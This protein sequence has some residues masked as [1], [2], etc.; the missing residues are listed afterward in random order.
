MRTMN[1]TNSTTTSRTAIVTGSAKGI[2]RCIAIQ[3]AQNGFHV[4]INY[5]NEAKRISQ[6][7]LLL[8][9]AAM[10]YRQLA[11]GQMFLRK[12]TAKRW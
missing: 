2:G 5:R 10:A 12:Q 7:K 11:F 6:K 4:V 9:A 3:L 1:K 8:H